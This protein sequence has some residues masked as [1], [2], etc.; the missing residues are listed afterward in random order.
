[1][2]YYVNSR[3]LKHFVD[4]CPQYF[5]LNILVNCMN[6]CL[7]LHTFGYT[8]SVFV[9]T[10]NRPIWTIFILHHCCTRVLRPIWVLPA[11]NV[12]YWKCHF[13]QIYRYKFCREINIFCL[14]FVWRSGLSARCISLLSFKGGIELS[15]YELLHGQERLISSS[16]LVVQN[17][18]YKSLIYL[19]K[20]YTINVCNYW[21]IS[22]TKI[23]HTQRPWLSFI[24]AWTLKI[25]KITFAV[26][27]L[28]AQIALCF[29]VVNF[30][31]SC[32]R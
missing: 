15:L 14:S 22:N 19:K 24:H 26:F 25:V 6:T 9:I 31:N 4:W 18:F 11:G 17:H 5:Y 2:Y 8:Y 27:S 10:G 16:Y 29:S 23:Y 1:M 32:Q 20:E 3:I 7:Y 28:Q 30:A 13:L 12:S 21:E